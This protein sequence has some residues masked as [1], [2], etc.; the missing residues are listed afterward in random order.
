MT[1]NTNVSFEDVQNSLVAI[2]A[3]SQKFPGFRLSEE[4]REKIEDATNEFEAGQQGKA[5]RLGQESER[6]L[7]AA[8]TSFFL[9]SPAYFAGQCQILDQRIGLEDETVEQVKGIL[10]PYKA[11]CEKAAKLKETGTPLDLDKAA[12]KYQYMIGMLETV[13]AID[14]KHKAEKAAAAR[15]A[16][17]KALEEKR[18]ADRAAQERLA[19]KRAA[20]KKVQE[21][22]QMAARQARAEKVS[23]LRAMLAQA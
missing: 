9:N 23:P 21:E 22:K 8:L 18:A 7:R 14:K 17:A 5:V 15:V 11:A 1:P 6:W 13:P 10:S 20:E 19:A 12:E 3:T 2:L 4:L 16:A